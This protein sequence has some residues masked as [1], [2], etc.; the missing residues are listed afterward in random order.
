MKNPDDIGYEIRSMSNLIKRKVYEINREDAQ[1]LTDMQGWIL[2]FLW[3]HQDQDI[4]QRDLEEAFCVRRS[5]ISRFLAA[6]EKQG[7]I[8]RISV[9]QDARLKK[10]V[11]TPKAI[12]L[13]ERVM[14]R[15]DFIESLVVKDISKEDVE[16]F[17]KIIKK[18]KENLS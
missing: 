18:M 13:H 17:H 15:I 3:E 14:Q 7:L 16:H 10:L 4:F 11:L 5:T 12:S 6:M 1:I 9:P 8:Q 2:G